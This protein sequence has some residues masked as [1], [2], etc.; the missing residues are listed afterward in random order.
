MT[1]TMLFAL[2]LAGC[3]TTSSSTAPGGYCS[4][5]DPRWPS[6]ARDYDRRTTLDAIAVLT[7]AAKADRDRLK[8]GARSDVGN[9][10]NEI[11]QRGTSSS[12]F[13]SS[14]VAELANRLRQLDCA[15]RANRLEY[16][17]AEASYGQILT[18]LQAERAT[19]EGS[20]T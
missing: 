19:L 8:T 9:S 20:G 11:Y 5:S 3:A 14:G 16:S 12:A 6:A 7:D 4:I 1:K 17:R 10:I 2:L 15:V 13:I 18:E